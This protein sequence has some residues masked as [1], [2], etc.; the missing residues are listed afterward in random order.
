M[1]GNYSQQRTVICMAQR[2]SDY[3][4]ST[5][6]V[7]GRLPYPMSFIRYTTRSRYCAEGYAHTLALHL[8]LS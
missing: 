4:R 5:T 3:I 6:H 2:A 7:Y 1:V 8:D